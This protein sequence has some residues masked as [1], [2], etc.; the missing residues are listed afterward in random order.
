MQNLP[1]YEPSDEVWK[2]IE[3]KLNE[4]V[5]HRAIKNLP[6]YEPEDAVWDKIET[7]LTPKKATKILQLNQ[8]KWW[9]AAASIVVLIG[10]FF[11][12]MTDNQSVSYSEEKINKNLLLNPADDSDAD[13]ERIVAFCKQEELVCQNP[14]FRHLKSELDELHEASQELKTAIG[15]YN[16]EP[17]LM[18]QLTEIEQQK[19]EIIK[20]MA[21]RVQG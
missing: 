1:Q 18:S 9:A 12:F 16:T 11:L 15:Q 7:E 14:E 17:E 2:N 10:I 8:W 20:K 4:D 5:L 13:Y 3:S 19:T 21:L 6:Q